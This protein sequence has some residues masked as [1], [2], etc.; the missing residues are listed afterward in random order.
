MDMKDENYFCRLC[1]KDLSRSTYE[2]RVNHVKKCSKTNKAP[3]LPSAEEAGA[4]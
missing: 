2:Q 1:S 3:T 4:R